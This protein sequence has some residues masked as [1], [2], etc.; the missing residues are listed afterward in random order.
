[1]PDF[2]T[3]D[4]FAGPGGLAEGF[5]SLRD[6]KGQRIFDIAL[7]VEKEPSAFSTLRL[8]SFFRQFATPPIEYYDYISGAISKDALVSAYP[9]EW[10][11]AVSETAMLELG[12]EEARIEIDD[13]LEKVIEKAGNDTVLIGGP[14]C[15][16]YSLVGR[17]RNQGIKGYVAS[18]DNRHF[19]YREYIRILERLRPAAFIMENVK[20]MLSSKVGGENII[21]R[22]LCDLKSAGGE[23]DSYSLIPIVEDDRGKLP[24]H[25]IRSEDYG[26]PQCRHRVILLG[27]RRDI[28]DAW[29][30][31]GRPMP[32]LRRSEEPARV[33]GVLQGM[34]RLRSGLS[35]A[36]DSPSA[37]RLA[38]A[39]ALR[40]AATACHSDG[41]WLSG[42]ATRL[43]DHARS[44]A[45]GDEVLPRQ[46]TTPAQISDERLAEWLGDENLHALPNHQTRGHME[47]DLARYGFAATFAEEFGRSP[48]ASE[49]P[50]ALAP[51]HGNWESGKFADRFRVQTWKAP[52]TTVTSHISKDGHYFIHPDPRQCRSLTVR[53]AARLQTFPDNYFFEGNRTQ[54]YVQ[55]GNAVP[56]LLAKQIAEVVAALIGGTCATT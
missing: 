34:A 48:K 32:M 49:F 50:A 21:E 13:R 2:K 26:I 8:R 15:Q 12:T 42:V 24:G 28:A 30:A 41:T 18:E 3:V 47:G 35:K 44:I 14:P 23:E 29:K 55:V 16:A 4:L 20:G 5:S 11:R 36:E 31:T 40:N 52:A 6:D 43:A 53:E 1:M 46:S 45:Q 38:A 9:A 17:A 51:N 25:L 37:W 10:A 33:K 39:R 54:Q 27:L 56:P 22:V 7:S 19:L